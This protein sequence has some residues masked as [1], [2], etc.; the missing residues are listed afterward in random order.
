MAAQPDSSQ[1]GALTA[2]CGSR[3]LG[4][5]ETGLLSRPCSRQHIAA[6]EGHF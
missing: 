1:L 6:G 5:R 3:V 4:R 2:E